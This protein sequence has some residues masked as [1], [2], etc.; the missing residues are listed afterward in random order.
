MNN[1]EILARKYG[2]DK[3]TND[4]GQPKIYHG[5]TDEYFKHLSVMQDKSFN[6]LEIG[7][8][9]GW[10]HFMWA[11]FFPKATIYG[12]D[13]FKEEGLNV[14]KEEIE[15]HGNIKIIVGDQADKD[16]LNQLKDIK[17]DVIIDDGS[18]LSYDQ[19]RSFKILWNNLYRG[20]FYFI[21]DLAV[22]L[23][24]NFREFEDMASSTLT[25]LEAMKKGI[26]PF[27]YYINSEDMKT[28]FSQIEYINI[29]GEIAIIKKR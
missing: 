3:R 5:Y 4:I 19:Q 27:S 8:R 21:E 24:R 22:C 10:S 11:D 26:I 20:G 23:N 17:F 28:V 9:E 6:L 2:T 14:T 7:V 12:I 1:L 18:H 16:A 15:E 25:W 29:V 13:N